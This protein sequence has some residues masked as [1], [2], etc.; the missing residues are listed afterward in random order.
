MAF[1]FIRRRGTVIN[2]PSFIKIYGS[3]TIYPGSVVATISGNRVE[4]ATS[5]TTSTMVFGISLDYIQGAS[6]SLVRV[7]P[8]VPGQLWEADCAN[9]AA[10]NQLLIKHALSNSLLINNTSTDQN[11]AVG[12][13]YAMGISRTIYA[14]LS[15]ATMKIIGEFIK[16]PGTV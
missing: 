7:I 9:T 1:K 15:S 12:V 5:S 10:T 2:T 14:S 8:F 3:G 11:V 16:K 6:D 4:P 13:F